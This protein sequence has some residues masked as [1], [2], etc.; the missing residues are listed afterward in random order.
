MAFDET[1]VDSYF[2]HPNGESGYSVKNNRSLSGIRKCLEGNNKRLAIGRNTAN[3]SGRRLDGSATEFLLSTWGRLEA[4]VDQQVKVCQ[5]LS[6]VRDP[7]A[8]SQL[9]NFAQIWS[10][11]KWSAKVCD[12][13]ADGMAKLF[14]SMIQIN[15]I[16]ES[17]SS[18]RSSE[19]PPSSTPIARENG[20]SAR[21]VDVQPSTNTSND[22]STSQAEQASPGNH[23]EH[24]ENVSAQTN[25]SSSLACP[26]ALNSR[27]PSAPAMGEAN[28]TKI[29]IRLHLPEDDKTAPRRMIWSQA[30]TRDE[31]F[32]QV[33]QRFREHSVQSVEA[34]LDVDKI[35]VEPTGSED[36]WEILQEDLLRMLRRSSNERL[37]VDAAVRVG[38][39]T[40]IKTPSRPTKRMR[41]R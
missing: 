23:A 9:V 17:A 29:I 13:Y 26:S 38:S 30:M 21:T 20:R 37:Q 28:S 34:V 22:L 27:H 18:E 11:K 7:V 3:F 40:A 39:D 25:D 36:E 15:A 5:H 6:T 24:V 12:D 31:F 33:A 32:Q 16:S 19:H 35:L 14:N 2:Q 1:K 10:L 41:S 8:I 4:A